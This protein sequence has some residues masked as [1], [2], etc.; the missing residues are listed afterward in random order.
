MY[1][2]VGEAWPLFKNS[3]I[4]NHIAIVV[5]CFV[6]YVCVWKVSTFKYLPHS[7]Y[8]YSKS[9]EITLKPATQTLNQQYSESQQV[10][11][12]STK[13]KAGVLVYNYID[14]LFRCL[15]MMLIIIIIIIIVSHILQLLLLLCYIYNHNFT[16]QLFSYCCSI[17][18]VGLKLIFVIKTRRL[19]ATLSKH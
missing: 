1:I 17:I 4:T 11:L 5:F 19:L 3:F 16:L 2:V 9:H 12:L 18:V 14:E 8:V 13:R 15:L 6:V 7:C 10:E